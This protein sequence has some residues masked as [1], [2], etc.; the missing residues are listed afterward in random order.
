MCQHQAEH[1]KNSRLQTHQ[2][3]IVLDPN[4]LATTIL[5]GDTTRHNI[6]IGIKYQVIHSVIRI[7][8][9]STYLYVHM[10]YVFLIVDMGW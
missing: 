9:P 1:V 3:Y 2:L 10:F 4:H 6:Q 8:W 5:T 7:N